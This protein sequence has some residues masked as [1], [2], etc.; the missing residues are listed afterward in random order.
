MTDFVESSIS[1]VGIVG[2]AR[3]CGLR[4]A[5]AECRMQNAELGDGVV[6]SSTANAECRMQN[7]E[8]GGGVAWASV[9]YAVCGIRGRGYVEPL[10]T[11]A[12]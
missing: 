1:S 3:H 5:N 11:A 8:L 4:P 6:R 9:A 7:A 10:F 2:Q 12:L